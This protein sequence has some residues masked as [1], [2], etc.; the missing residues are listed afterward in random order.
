M[1]KYTTI[2]LKM[3]IDSKYLILATISEKAHSRF[4]Y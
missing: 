3:I 2:R 4:Y 1:I